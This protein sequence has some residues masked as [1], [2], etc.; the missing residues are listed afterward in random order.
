MMSRKAGNVTNAG[1]F[2]KDVYSHVR[3]V[4]FGIQKLM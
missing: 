2:R 3:R 1:L 4:A